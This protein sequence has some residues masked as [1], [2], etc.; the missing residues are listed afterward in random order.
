MPTLTL[1]IPLC[2]FTQPLVVAFYVCMS[3]GMAF[4]ILLDTLRTSNKSLTREHTSIHRMLQKL[5]P[6]PI[7]LGQNEA[8]LGLTE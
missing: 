6:K 1:S 2:L 5:L 4:L 7:Y 3:P 8:G